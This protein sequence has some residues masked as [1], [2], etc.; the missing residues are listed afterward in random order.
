MMMRKRLPLGVLTTA[1]GVLFGCTSAD[2]P[3]PRPKAERPRLAKFVAVEG[4]V[5]VQPWSV[6]EWGS[7]RVGL[8]VGEGDAIRTASTSE[9]EL[10]YL[11]GMKLS[12]RPDSYIRIESP[13]TTGISGEVVF[14]AP[15][16]DNTVLKGGNLEVRA[17]R[18]QARTGEIVVSAEGY[19][20]V[21]Q[22]GGASRVVSGGRELV[23]DKGQEVSVDPKGAAGP[24]KS[25]LDAPVLSAPPPQADLAYP[26]PSRTPI[27]LVWTRVEGAASYHVK[28]YADAA[29]GSPLVD[30]VVTGE[31]MVTL[32]PLAVGRYTWQVNSVSADGVEGFPSDLSTF[33]VRAAPAMA[34][35][36]LVIDVLE[37][38]DLAVKIE[39]RTD[40][41]ARV[42]VNGEVVEVDAGGRFSEHLVLPPG[43]T[44]VVVR[45]RVDTGGTSELVR[46]LPAEAP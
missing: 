43:Q 18:G 32:Q 23:L 33:G 1:V 28:V 12:I 2:K 14:T 10:E 31:T 13:D 42:T 36:P 44:R 46:D 4:S 15:E 39:G 19:A 37:R 3:D 27:I 30:R 22:R 6:F 45:A 5:K 8:G 25:L 35:P 9:A 24:V 17:E 40:R 16:K 20:K 26:D 38:Q 41:R 11:D 34:G 29:P 7:A 21:R